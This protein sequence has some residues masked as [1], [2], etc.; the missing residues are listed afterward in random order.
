MLPVM[1]LQYA[2]RNLLTTKATKQIQDLQDTKSVKDMLEQNLFR[3]KGR[4]ESKKGS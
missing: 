3:L 1:L 4:R 2:W